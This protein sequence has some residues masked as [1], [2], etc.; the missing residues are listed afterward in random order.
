[1]P[2]RFALL[3]ALTCVL[4]SCGYHVAG[5][6]TQIPTTVKTVAVPAFRNETSRY[7]IEQVLTQA[8]MRELLAR[9]RFRVQPEAAG[10]DAVLTGS[11]IQFWSFPVVVEST[12]G[13]TTAVQISV[14]MRV[15]LTDSKTGKV[16]YENPGFMFN[17]NYE[18]SGDAARY[19]EES[20][21]AMERLGRTF[22]ASL[23]SSI[24]EAF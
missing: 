12:G 13:R 2:F 18:I 23:V 3:L 15:R 20:T 4:S 14:R 16:L 5:R 7:R 11:V 1:M 21:P 19:F 24:L 10:A 22:A 17:E 9:T 8:V 6:G